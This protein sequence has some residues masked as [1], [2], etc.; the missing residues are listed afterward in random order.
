MAAVLSPRLRNIVEALPLA[1]GLRV[2]EIGCG[3]GA[4]ARAVAARIEGGHLLGIDRSARAIAQ[5]MALSAEDMAN[6]RL[7]FRTQSAEEF[8]LLPDEPRYD[9]AF[10]VRVGAFDGRYPEAG[11]QA[12]AR[13][14]AALKPGGRLFVD[15][16]NPLREILLGDGI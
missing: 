8:V 7:S 12:L 2:I 14:R 3:P 16:G 1:P 9:L 10:A 15:G 4:A 6:G 13:L 11:K 5:A